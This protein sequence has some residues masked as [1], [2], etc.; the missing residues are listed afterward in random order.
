VKES[1]G[2]TMAPVSDRREAV[3]VAAKAFEG[4]NL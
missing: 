3:N 4:V 1:S 2:A